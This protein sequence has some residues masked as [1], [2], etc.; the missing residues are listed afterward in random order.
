MWE[1]KTSDATFTEGGRSALGRVNPVVGC[2]LH[3]GSPR[4]VRLRYGLEVDARFFLPLI[5][6]TS[7]SK[8]FVSA[9]MPAYAAVS[10]K[11]RQQLVSSGKFGLSCIIMVHQIWLTG[12]TGTATYSSLPR[13]VALKV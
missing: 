3:L 4:V 7:S 2:E 1:T 13:K 10:E 11:A 12:A 6:M 9:T 8:L 5:R